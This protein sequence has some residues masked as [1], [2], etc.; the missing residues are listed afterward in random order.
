MAMLTIRNIDDDLKA[1]LRLKA[2]QAGCSV[3]E[4]VRV[5][6][7]Q[8]T[9]AAAPTM[10]DAPRAAARQRLLARLAQQPASGPLSWARDEL[11]D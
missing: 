2:A 5:I 10:A 1:R 4:T 8:A 7:R 3:E 9:T 6:L 11:Y